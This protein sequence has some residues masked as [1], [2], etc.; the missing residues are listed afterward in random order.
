MLFTVHTFVSRSVADQI[1]WIPPSVSECLCVQRSTGSP[2]TTSSWVGSWARDSSERFTMEFT[3]AQ[4]VC[5]LSKTVSSLPNITLKDQNKI[6]WWW[7]DVCFQTGERI[8]VAIKTCKDVSA[9][10]KEK[11]LSEASEYAAL[12][13]TSL[14][15]CRD[16]RCNCKAWQMFTTGSVKLCKI[17]FVSRIFHT[18]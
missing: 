15:S 7:K 10:V 3:K 2:E 5:L 16:L 14:A 17:T 12:I 13:I 18:F 4:W 6:C 1:S 11:F 9:E 8:C